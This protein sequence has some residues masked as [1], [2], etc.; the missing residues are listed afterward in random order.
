MKNILKIMNKELMRVFKSKRML[1][2]LLLPGVLIYVMYTAMGSV[3]QST[4]EKE[5]ANAKADSYV[6]YTTNTVE[7]IDVL[8]S[9]IG[10]NGFID[11]DEKVLIEGLGYNFQYTQITTDA[12]ESSAALVK[13]G[14]VDLILSF[15]ADFFTT[16]FKAI[17]GTEHKPHYNVVYNPGS[18]KSE[19]AFSAVFMPAINAFKEYVLSEVLDYDT[20]IFTSLV[21]V[22]IDGNRMMADLMA[23]M[24]PM[25]MIMLL[26]SGCIAVAP[27][28]IAGEKERG[29]M[30]TLLAT[31]ARRSDIAIGK[32]AALSILALISGL[33]TFIGLIASFPKLM[34]G[35]PGS[36]SFFALYSFA[37]ILL[38][39]L[40]IMSTVLVMIGLI[41]MV[42]SFSK[43]VK[44]ASMLV[45]PLM[46]L[47]LIVGMLNMFIT[48]P[49]SF[50]FYLIPLYNAVAAISSILT[51]EIVFV[52]LAVTVLSNIVYVA[53]FV[54]VLT[55]L[56]NSEKVMFSK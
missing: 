56:F 30:A 35:V 29:T 37:D 2:T 21:M 18:A 26:F 46:V 49:T 19:Y 22:E 33:S 32:I 3:I 11:I 28:S 6:V 36:S 23:N 52:N 54:W 31:P 16:D 50:L 8:T 44:E 51:F 43:N 12:I 48:A 1:L 45:T 14:E 7:E 47:G 9:I 5:T 38:L 10:S 4:I 15:D 24:L 53:A 41:S 34:S 55:K 27:E 40:V 17:S 13:S 20:N 25:I 39:L 42:S